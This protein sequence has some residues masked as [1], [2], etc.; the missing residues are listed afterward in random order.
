MPLGARASAIPWIS[1]TK[2]AERFVGVGLG[3]VCPGEEHT[4][5]LPELV[6]GLGYLSPTQLTQARATASRCQLDANWCVTCSA[7]KRR[8]GAST[9]DIS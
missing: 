4:L 9:C 1:A 6:H 5:S 7:C 2:A 8:A 3:D